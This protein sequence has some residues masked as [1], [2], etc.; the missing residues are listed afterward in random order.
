MLDDKDNEVNLWDAL[1]VKSEGNI[2]K[3]VI[4][5][6]Y[7]KLDGTEFSKDDIILMTNRI[8]AT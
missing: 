3:L 6:G 8:R 7:K 5:E 2:H 1:K 4:K